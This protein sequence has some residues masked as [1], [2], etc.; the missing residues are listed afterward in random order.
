LI[1][2]GHKNDLE[3]FSSISASRYFKAF[4]R[5]ID[6]ETTPVWLKYSLMYSP[7]NDPHKLNMVNFGRQMKKDANVKFEKVTVLIMKFPL[8]KKILYHGKLGF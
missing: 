4:S 2:T 5:G 7:G 1:Q 3:G 6:Q 8:K